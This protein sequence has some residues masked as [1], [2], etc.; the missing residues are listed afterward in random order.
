MRWVCW[1]CSCVEKEMV[2]LR[3]IGIFLE[4]NSENTY[5]KLN[6][7]LRSVSE[8][9]PLINCLKMVLTLCFKEKNKIQK[10]F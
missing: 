9:L 10:H 8:N 6:K 3:L 2:R 5:L 4:N 7:G 1:W